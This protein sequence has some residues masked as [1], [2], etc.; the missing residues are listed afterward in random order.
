MVICRLCK[1]PIHEQFIDRHMK[2]YHK[3]IYNITDAEVVDVRSRSLQ[4][5]LEDMAG[6]S[7]SQ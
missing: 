2:I 5:N 7:C 6:E 3:E 1:E 4:L